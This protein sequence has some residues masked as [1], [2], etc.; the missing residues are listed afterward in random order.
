MAKN[1]R[2]SC[3][4]FYFHSCTVTLSTH[5]HVTARESRHEAKHEPKQVGKITFWD[6]KF[7]SK[8]VQAGTIGRLLSQAPTLKYAVVSTRC[9][10][11]RSG[12]CVRGRSPLATMLDVPYTHGIFTG[13]LEV[14]GHPE[15]YKNAFEDSAE[16]VACKPLRARISMQ[17][18]RSFVSTSSPA[19]PSALSFVEEYDVQ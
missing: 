18:G 17:R 11:T 15:L 13:T 2:S 3:I 16:A 19:D 9:D 6:K 12:C 4:S 5:L 7:S 1:I 10:A 14:S 8:C